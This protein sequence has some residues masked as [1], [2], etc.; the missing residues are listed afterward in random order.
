MSTAQQS[1]ETGRRILSG[2]TIVSGVIAGMVAGAVMAMY[3]M[4]ASA[5]FLHQGFFTPLYG[6]ASPL[7]GRDA[8]MT[9]MQRGVYF[10]FGPV[11]LGLVV[12]MMWAAVFGVVF[13][14]YVRASRLHDIQALAAGLLYG[15]V[16]E[17]VMSLVVL[18]VVGVGGMPGTIGV[19]SFTVEHV[20]FGLSLGLWVVLRP[21]GVGIGTPRRA[22]G[23]RYVQHSA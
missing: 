23:S 9:S 16:I 15:L 6:I 8:M 19:S 1:R 5:T 22:N 4:L 10:A 18:P 11:L 21:Q 13:A 2:K 7:I 14:L 20:L 3:A 17:L 12:H